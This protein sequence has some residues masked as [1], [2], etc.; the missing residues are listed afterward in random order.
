VAVCEDRVFVT[1]SYLGSIQVFDMSGIFLGV[2]ADDGGLP[3]KLTTPT[4]ITVDV[5][6]KRLYIVEL[7]GHRVCRVDLE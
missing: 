6:R 5:N 4:G 1:D 3:M 7:K 2:L